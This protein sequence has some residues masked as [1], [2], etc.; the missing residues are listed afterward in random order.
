M[1]TDRTTLRGLSPPPRKRAAVANGVERAARS[2]LEARTSADVRAG[3]RV[4]KP[5]RPSMQAAPSAV[6]PVGTPLS[7]ADAQLAG[8]ETHS[9]VH[10]RPSVSH[11]CR[12]A[13]E[14][15]SC[16]LSSKLARLTPFGKWAEP[17]GTALR[18]RH[19]DAVDERDEADA[20]DGSRASDMPS[21]TVFAGQRRSKKLSSSPGFDPTF[22]SPS[23]RR[24]VPT[25]RH[26][27]VWRGTSD[28][29]SL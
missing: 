6:V 24:C 20:S 10:A 4:A 15:P 18:R 9:C 17:T 5:A 2:V 27:R 23:Q 1:P 14:R 26:K 3:E 28:R 16:N 13:G 29:V 22:G 8:S 7:S 19:E 12:C 21:E 11:I 25:P